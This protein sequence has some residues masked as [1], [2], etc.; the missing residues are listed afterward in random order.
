MPQRYSTFKK[1][2]LFLM[3]LLYIAAGINHF[4]HP[5]FYQKIMPPYIPWHMPLIYVSGIFEMVL[6][7]LLIFNRTEKLAAWGIILLLIAVFPA[8]I[9]MAVNYINQKNPA[10]WIAVLRLPFQLVLIWWAYIFTK[11]K[12]NNSY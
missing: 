10:L 4:I 3:S 6:G 9:Y 5:L 1:I 8:N 2:S 11:Q 12:R 7:I